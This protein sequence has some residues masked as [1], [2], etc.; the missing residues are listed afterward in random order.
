MIHKTTRDKIVAQALDEIQHARWYKQGRINDW[1]KNENLL[2][3]DKR[4]KV[5]SQE[6]RSQV[7]LHKMRGFI[8]TILS[9]IDSPLLFKFV[10]THPADHRKAKITNALRE[11]DAELDNWEFKDL[12]GKEQAILYGRAIYRYKAS[13]ENK[14][15]ASTLDNVDVY[16]FLIDPNAGGLDL[17]KARYLG[18]Y[19]IELSKQEL[20]RGRKDGLY[21]RDEVKALIEGAGNNNETTQE[22]TNKDNRYEQF[23]MTTDRELYDP[24]IYKF[25][26]WFTTYEGERYYLL[27][28]ETGGRAI[29]VEKLKDIT[30]SD[31][32]PFW[33]W[34]VFPSLTEFW[35][36]SFADIA[37]E[38][39][40]AQSVSINQM[41]DNAEQ[42]NKP[43]RA[44]DT[45]LVKDISE[46]KFKKSGIIRLKKG[47]DPN[48][49]L[50]ILETP[51]IDT[52]LA[53]Y[54]ALENIIQL[55]TGV[56]GAIQG[57]A[58]EDKVGIYEGNQ[59]ATSDR[60]NL[61]NKSYSNAYKQFAQLYL[62]GIK[63]HLNNRIAV[64]MIGPDGVEVENIKWNDIKPHNEFSIAIQSSSSDSASDLI[65][66]RNKL[67]FLDK[68][69]ASGVINPQAA[70]EIEAEIAGFSPDEIKRLSDMDNS[71]NTEV[72]GEAYRDIEDIIQGKEV[73]P[74]MIADQYYMKIIF[75]YMKDKRENLTDKQFFALA[76]Y[77]EAIQPVV[78]RNMA[79]DIQSQ[80]AQQ[81]Q[82][83]EQGGVP[84]INQPQREEQLPPQEAQL[85][86]ESDQISL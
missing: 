74:N 54:E 49:V 16:D 70:V 27:L 48:K 65:D 80:M 1:H 43:Q 61:L 66:R 28:Q 19:N 59:A 55:Q 71:T 42:I 29:R 31:L 58:E 32:F 34:A 72:M 35:T 33:S 38:V 20:E 77:F 51:Q 64:K 53:V 10:A 37:R 6:S 26:E 5:Q 62:W 76:D 17:Q 36:Q 21:I 79:F 12:L 39:F 86:L 83:T 11:R 24:N 7:A 82:L 30:D 14:E 78:M 69:A 73:E 47:A 13:S 75:D 18:T 8:S 85:E 50:R 4:H 45:S 15:Y 44:V 52:P 56:T 84:N 41:L 3:E 63:E 2:W 68:Y 81:G 57:V 25:W 40:M 9:K 60:F 22:S 23:K 67:T 46:L